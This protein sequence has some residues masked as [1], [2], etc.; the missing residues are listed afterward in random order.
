MSPETTESCP[1]GHQILPWGTLFPV[2]GDTKPCP[3]GH[4][5]LT[6]GTLS[7]VLAMGWGT[8]AE[9]P[10][11]ITPNPKNTGRSLL[12]TIPKAMWNDRNILLCL[13]FRVLVPSM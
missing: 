8:P 13:S 9:T 2:P 7:P 3:E 1:G 11:Q 5:A 10:T 6:L 12:L 4:Q